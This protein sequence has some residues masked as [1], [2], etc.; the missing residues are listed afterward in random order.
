MASRKPNSRGHSYGEGRQADLYNTGMPGDN[1]FQSMYQA[2]IGARAQSTNQNTRQKTY[3]QTPM[4]KS[5]KMNNHW[6]NNMSKSQTKLNLT[7]KREQI[8]RFGEYHGEDGMDAEAHNTQSIWTQ[9]ACK[10]NF[11]LAAASYQNLFAKSAQ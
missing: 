10:Y 7:A 6:N 2:T 9:S 3:S 8:R 11:S 4:H 5:N 1:P